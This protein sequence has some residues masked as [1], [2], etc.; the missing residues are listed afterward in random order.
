[1]HISDDPNGYYRTFLDVE[2]L[3][4]VNDELIITGGSTF[5]FVA[6]IKTQKCHGLLILRKKRIKGVVSS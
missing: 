1:M 6:A 5:G 4:K 2:L 3:S